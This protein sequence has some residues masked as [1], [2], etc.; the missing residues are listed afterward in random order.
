MEILFRTLNREFQ[1]CFENS[2]QVYKSTSLQVKYRS[3][4]CG[5][6][7]PRLTPDGGVYPLWSTLFSCFGVRRRRM[8]VYPEN[9]RVFSF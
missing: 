6:R 1:L 5:V 2:P 7:R 4:Q 8:W 9:S 3:K